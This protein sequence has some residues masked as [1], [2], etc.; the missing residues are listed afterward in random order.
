[1][2]ASAPAGLIVVRYSEIGLKGENRSFFE[3][4]LVRN[5]R[6]RL[7]GLPVERVERRRGRV[8]V[9]LATPSESDGARAALNR[10]CDTPGVRSASPARPVSGEIAAIEAVAVALAREAV[11]RPKRPRTFRIEAT[12]ADKS[13]PLTSMEIDT[14]L[15]AAVLAAVP[16]LKVKLVGP[17]LTIGV[18][19][20]PGGAFV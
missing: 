16:D 14:R 18:E 10:L 4:L 13:F 15:G 1:M 7:F 9:R 17:D 8:L 5:I 12:R 2:D 3:H 20:Q 6:D 11:A 19:V